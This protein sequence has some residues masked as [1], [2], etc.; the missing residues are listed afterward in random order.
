MGN[1]STKL[2]AIIQSPGHQFTFKDLN[3]LYCFLGVEVISTNTGLFLIQ[4][5]YIHDLLSSYKLDGAKPTH[6]PLFI[7]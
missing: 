4:H 1:N 6:T 5:N 3:N 2:D 7:L